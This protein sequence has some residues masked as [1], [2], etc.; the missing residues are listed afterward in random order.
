M[1]PEDIVKIVKYPYMA[2]DK[3]GDWYNYEKEPY[4]DDSDDTCWI[5]NT[6]ADYYIPFANIEYTGDWKDSLVV[7]ASRVERQP[8][9]G[10]IVEYIAQGTRSDQITE[11]D[12]IKSHPTLKIT[13]NSTIKEIDDWYVKKCHQQNQMEFKIIKLG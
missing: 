9:E 4:V 1:K 3:D 12:Y 8:V 6:G 7:D 2:M 13:E 10:Q 5:P 11:D